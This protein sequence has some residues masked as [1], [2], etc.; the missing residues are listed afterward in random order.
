MTQIV[1]S[2]DCAGI[3]KIASPPRGGRGKFVSVKFRLFHALALL[4]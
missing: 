4:I 3:A 2:C 1:F